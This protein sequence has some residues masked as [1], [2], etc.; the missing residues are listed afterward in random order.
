MLLSENL[1]GY[2]LNSLKNIRI[3]KVSISSTQ[4][5]LCNV[6]SSVVLIYCF[7]HTFGFVLQSCSTTYR[8]L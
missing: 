5:V 3:R 8:T 1:I 7:T 4:L 6:L 2:L